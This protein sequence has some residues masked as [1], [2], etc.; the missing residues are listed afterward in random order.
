[1]HTFCSLTI[2]CFKKKNLEWFPR[3]RAMHLDSH[4]KEEE[5]NEINHLRNRLDVTNSLVLQL[6]KQ[7]EDLKDKVVVI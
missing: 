6:T 7:I 2:S 3:M 1:M 4:G 5:D